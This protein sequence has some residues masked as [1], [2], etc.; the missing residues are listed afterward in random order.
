MSDLFIA[1]P[2]ASALTGVEIA[3]LYEQQP[4]VNRFSDENQRKLS[5]LRLIAFVNNASELASVDT[6]RYQI[7]TDGHSWFDWRVGDLSSMIAIDPLAAIY[8]PPNSDNSGASGA[9]VRRYVNGA[10]FA[11]FGSVADSTSI[12]T[13]TDNWPMLRAAHDTCVALRIP[14]FVGPGTYRIVPTEPLDFPLE[15]GII[16]GVGEVYSRF[17]VDPGLTL[18]LGENGVGTGDAIRPDKFHAH[19]TGLHIVGNSDCVL[20]L[21]S[22]DLET[23]VINTYNVDVKVNNERETLDCVAFEV[24]RVLESH[25]RAV[26]N[27]AMSGNPQYHATG[28]GIAMRVAQARFTTFDLSLGNANLGLQMTGGF[29]RSNRFVTTNIEEVRR[30]ILIDDDNVRS[31]K[32]QCGT[33]ISVTAFEC[34]A[35][36]NNTFSEMI[37]GFYDG[38]QLFEPGGER[39]IL[40]KCVVPSVVP[41]D[42]PAPVSSVPTRNLTGRKLFVRCEG[43][44]TS[45][46]LLKMDGVTY[47]LG[48]LGAG[49]PLTFCW[50]PY[51]QITVN[52]NN[53]L[54]W[55]FIP[56]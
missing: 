4:D 10:N 14:L 17:N 26:C 21:G 41:I 49:Y 3:T 36:F 12:G 29:A 16:R 1:G 13:G 45:F 38:G 31:N 46:E 5:D 35:G 54:N 48:A 43:E 20:R 27:C 25:I 33:I 23:S 22:T 11:W 24:N 2:G 39:A 6:A 8:I 34:T 30:G 9:W 42:V 44:I 52:Y 32:F 55:S 19:F 47:P 56:E 18:E 51:E 15:G 50:E 7:G 40:T 28:F 37:I 53:A